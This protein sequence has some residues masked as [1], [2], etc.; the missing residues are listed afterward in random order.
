MTLESPCVREYKQAQ[1]R[2]VEAVKNSAAK[3]HQS[4]H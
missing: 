1:D 2:I 4:D 3:K